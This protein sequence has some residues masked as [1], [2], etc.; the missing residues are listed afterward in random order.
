MLNN[1]KSFIKYSKY[2][3]NKLCPNIIGKIIVAIIFLI[4][5]ELLSLRL[6]SLIIFEQS[7]EQ[8]N[9]TLSMKLINNENFLNPIRISY[10]GDLIML[11]DQVI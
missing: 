5:L 8:K 9:I 10:I 6:K 3:Y 7:K 1:V 11:K 4:F 2:I